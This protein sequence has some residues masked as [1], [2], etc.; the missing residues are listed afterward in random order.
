[1]AT[2]YITLPTAFTLQYAD[3]TCLVA[4]CPAACQH[5]L[6]IVELW[7]VWSGMKAK[8]KKC[9]CIGLEGSSGHVVNPHLTLSSQNLPFIG[10]DSIKYLGLPTQIPHD[11]SK[12]KSQLKELLNHLLKLVDQ[13]LVTMK[14]KLKLYK[15]GVC[16]CVRRIAEDN[17]I[18]ET[19]SQ[20]KKFCPAKIVSNAPD[21]SITIKESSDSG[22]KSEVTKNNE[23]RRRSELHRLLYQGRMWQSL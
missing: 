3:D 2:I 15:L 23:V 6:Q 19:A 8:I 14:Q 9:H 21:G 12:A 5:L 1:M 13:S 16:P 10:N 22:N 4:N 11:A 20:R 18:L 17:L 7:L